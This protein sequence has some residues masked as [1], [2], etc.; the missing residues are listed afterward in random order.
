M[1]EVEI[2]VPEVMDMIGGSELDLPT[3][4][5]LSFGSGYLGDRTEGLRTFQLSM[6]PESYPVR[7]YLHTYTYAPLQTWV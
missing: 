7:Y 5:F 2:S 1:A 6:Q 4:A 3:L